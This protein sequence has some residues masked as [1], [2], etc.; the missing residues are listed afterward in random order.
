L[1]DILKSH[2]DISGMPREGVKFT[3][4]FPDMQEGGWIRMAYH[5]RNFP[6]CF[7]SIDEAREILNRDWGFWA[8]KGNEFFLEKS[9]THSF[10]I[11]FLKTVFPNACFIGITRDGYCSTEG[12][13]RR[14][15]PLNDA[16]KALNSNMYPVELCAKQWVYINK[17]ILRAQT[18]GVR[19]K[20]IKFEDF[21]S[22]P[23]KVLKD[24]FD[25]IGADT[26]YLSGKNNTV[27]I[28]Q[29]KFEI[30]NFNPESR[31]RFP[32]SKV[33]EFNTHAGELMRYF[34]YK[35]M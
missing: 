34:G 17:S 19:I 2:P 24:I 11:P 4:V 33:D 31:M 27:S 28:L 9:I 8:D 22:C 30:R 18:D 5:N 25:F 35:L 7:F 26:E 14:A 20:H 6:A 1:R 3:N 13:L 16:A 32:A 29:K 21:V 15:K 23:H 10:R 12:I